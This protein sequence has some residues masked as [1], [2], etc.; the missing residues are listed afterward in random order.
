MTAEEILKTIHDHCLSVRR[1]V[2][3][4]WGMYEMRHYREG[5]EIVIR[6][7][8]QVHPDFKR[9]FAK[10]FP[11]GRQFCR[12]RTIHDTDGHYMV[13]KMSDRGSIQR[14]DYKRDFGAPTLE[15]SISLFLASLSKN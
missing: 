2:T 8:D 5:D 12:R 14:W 9:S 7:I 11:N 15:A 10:Q 13:Q 4:D 3:E 6:T 1:I